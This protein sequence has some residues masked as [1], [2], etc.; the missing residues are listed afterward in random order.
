[1]SVKKI[2]KQINT[3][4]YIN[5]SLTILFLILILIFKSYGNREANRF[6]STLVLV[7]T[8]IFSIALPI[9]L[10]TGYYQKSIKNK[11]LKLS[12]YF[13]FKLLLNI[14]V[15]IGSLFALIGYYYPIY[16]YHL[17]LSVFVGLWGVYSI[18]PSTK[19]IEKDFIAYNI[20][21]EE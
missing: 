11:G 8:T 2:T 20:E 16:K 19:I 14:S 21:R 5:Y 12:E 9:L 6:N 13:N 18:I 4:T 3:I 1:V 7:S 17:Y 15:F 10:R